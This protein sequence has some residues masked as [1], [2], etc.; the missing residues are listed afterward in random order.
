MS[1]RLPEAVAENLEGVLSRWREKL[2]IRWL[3][4]E[5]WHLTVIPPF[6][7]DEGELSAVEEI[8]EKT[9]KAFEPFELQFHALLFAP[10]GSRARMVWLSGKPNE[11][12]EALK[13][14]LEG[15]IVREKAVPSFRQEKRRLV[16]HV[17]LARFREDDLSRAWQKTRILE[18][19][20]LSC[21]VESLEM[22]ESHL[23][24]SGAE[25]ETLL[26]VPL[27]SAKPL[28]YEFLP[29]TADVRIVARGATLKELFENALRGMAEY[30]KR[31][32]SFGT[33]TSSRPIE[34]SASDATLLLVDFL[35]RALALAD[36]NGEV[37]PRVSF[38]EF[39][40]THL[41]GTLRGFPVESFD[42]DVKAVTYHE[43][44]IRKT[45]EGYEVTIVCDI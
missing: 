3:P 16:P 5:N 42:E 26:R 10:P 24:R 13:E 31:G 39:S 12:L 18:D 8:L 40:E 43:A 15:E 9:A 7:A 1:I 29:H 27:G 6:Y 25:Y 2:P 38:D 20:K 14:A 22:T 45:A 41:R 36:A 32:S 4:K 30:M 21:V 11:K 28:P 17:T 23:K 44:E 34:V 19:L 33:L 37:Y 35:S